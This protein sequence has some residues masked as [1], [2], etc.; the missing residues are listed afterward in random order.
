MCTVNNWIWFLVLVL[1][2]QPYQHFLSSQLKQN[3]EFLTMLKKI[4]TTT[5]NTI[6]CNICLTPPFYFMSAILLEVFHLIF[7]FYL[8]FDHITFLNEMLFQLQNETLRN[9]VVEKCKKKKKTK[10]AWVS[11][12]NYPFKYKKMKFFNVFRNFLFLPPKC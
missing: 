9:F 12:V 3:P 1:L 11:K 5:E 8:L 6:Q 10:P 7:L 4:K 2:E